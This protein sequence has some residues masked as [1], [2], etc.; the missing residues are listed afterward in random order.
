MDETEEAIRRSLLETPAAGGPSSSREAATDEQS[1]LR[2]RQLLCGTPLDHD[3]DALSHLMGVMG[4]RLLMISAAVSK[5][6]RNAARARI[7]AWRVLS[8]ESVVGAAKLAWPLFGAPLPDGGISCAPV[9]RKLP[10]TTLRRT[11]LP[12]QDGPTTQVLPRPGSA[13][14]EE[15]ID[16]LTPPPEYVAPIRKPY[17]RGMLPQQAQQLPDQQE[18]LSEADRL[19]RLPPEHT[20]RRLSGPAGIACH[21]G[22]IFVVV[23]ASPYEW[24]YVSDIARRPPASARVLRLRE[25]DGALL[26]ASPL[27]KVARPKG[28][29]VADNKVFVADGAGGEDCIAVLDATTLQPENSF[30]PGHGQLSGVEE[31]A[32]PCGLTV[33]GFE[34]IVCDRG[35]HRLRVLS[36]S[37]EAVRDIGSEGRRPG[38]FKEPTSCIVAHGRLFTAEAAGARLQVLTMAGEPLQVLPMPTANRLKSPLYL[39]ISPTS[40]HASPLYLARCSRCPR[41]TA[42]RRACTG[43]A[44]ETASGSCGPPTPTAT[45]STA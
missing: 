1:R 9:E 18:E 19:F 45:C 29:A 8:H 40:P 30:G 15:I 11:G 27:L 41:P 36:F 4:M 13:R 37:G 16:A 32:S 44:S 42:C 10:D 22:C 24:T 21:D 2:P 35:A 14:T 17:P 31:L 34:L 23:S 33:H 5:P 12:Q 25:H 26:T 3:E 28:L 39:P 43:C 20:A 6:W 38:E 7:G